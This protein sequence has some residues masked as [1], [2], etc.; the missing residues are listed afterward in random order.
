[1]KEVKDMINGTT[2]VAL[3]LPVVSFVFNAVICTV[4]CL[5]TASAN[6][7]APSDPPSILTLQ[8][9]VD[10]LEK[11][12]EQLKYR[13][14]DLHH[15]IPE[16][17]EAVRLKKAELKNDPALEG[18]RR[19]AEALK[20]DIDSEV[21]L[22][23]E[24]AE[25]QQRIQDLLD[26]I[27][28]LTGQVKSADAVLVVSENLKEDPDPEEV[29]RISRNTDRTIAR[30]KSLRSTLT[31]ERKELESLRLSLMKSHPELKRKWAA[32]L[33]KKHLLDHELRM[34]H[35]QAAD[36]QKYRK[37]REELSQLK[38]EQ[39]S[40]RDRIFAIHLQIDKHKQDREI[41]DLQVEKRGNP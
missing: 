7:S 39:K 4:I 30:I 35:E 15:E 22:N 5:S 3:R 40:V 23:P 41:D 11:R 33:E 12:M 32:Y 2:G 20:N 17:V 1:M 36:F 13:E 6:P 21:A 8:Q 9:E 27:D 34:Q 37:L 29:A 28:E 31:Q 14:M 10:A 24:V 38:R 18:R 19:E 25:K 16:A 26:Q